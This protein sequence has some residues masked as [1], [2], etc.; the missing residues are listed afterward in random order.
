MTGN[1]TAQGI[2]TPPSAVGQLD[3]PE[4]LVPLK[5]VEDLCSALKAEGVNYCHWKSNDALALSATG[6]NDL[7]LLID[8]A[9]GPRFSEIL[10]LLGFKE[11]LASRA[12]RV[13]GVVH[14]L[15]VDGP[16][17]RFVHI[18]AHYELV[19]GD[20][21][22]KN[23]RLPME[24]AYLTSSVQ[25]RLF[26]VPAPEYEFIG[27]MVRM[28]LKHAT[29][30]AV[31]FLRG[32]MTGAERREFAFLHERVDLDRVHSLLDRDL[33]MV[34]RG[35]FERCLEALQ[36]DASLRF[37]LATGRA[38]R[39]CLA[40]SGRRVWWADTG[41]RVWHRLSWGFVRRV[42][43]RTP[44]KRLAGG[45]AL[46]AVVGGD[47]A[48][49]SSVV[50][51]LS[52]WLGQHFETATVHLGKPPRSMISIMYKCVI[53]AGRKVFGASQNAD[54]PPLSLVAEGSSRIP[55]TPWLIWH[56]LRA[57]DRRRAYRRVRRHVSRGALVVTDRFPLRQIKMMDGPIADLAMEATEGRPV[58]TRLAHW[59]KAY[60]EHIED[61]DVLVVLRI[62]PDVA[63]ARR[64]DEDEDFVRTRCAEVWRADWERTPA[65]V[66]DAGRS[67]SEVLSEVKVCVWSRL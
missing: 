17:G 11:A 34:D 61:P 9:H 24:C 13:P 59:E 35:L 14:F 47:G 48:G 66:I 39:R 8:E 43:G 5:L 12:R 26:R 49:K 29:W 37:R 19:V 42:L 27:L 56:V 63:V 38:L 45:G 41:L 60:Y 7:D 31:L 64:S 15:G 40:G 67:K 36:A 55:G 16:T 22:T 25:G 57:R 2:R 6:H 3:P 21:T 32:V 44:H 30:D 33:P 53:V 54:R 62:D 23:Y 58:L 4:G 20:D 52:S 50:D 28:L 51:G 46:I 65:V 10:R 1:E 18:H